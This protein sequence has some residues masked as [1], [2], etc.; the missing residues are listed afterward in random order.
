MRSVPVSPWRRLRKLT[1]IDPGSWCRSKRLSRRAKSFRRRL[2]REKLDDAHAAWPQAQGLCRPRLAQ[3]AQ[4]Q[5]QPKCV[6]AARALKLHP[7]YKRVDTCAAEFATNTA[8]MYSTYEEE[9]EANPPT[10]KRSWCWVAAPTVSARASS[11]TT[12]ACT[13]PWR[14]AKTAT[15][16][17]WSTATPKPCPPI[18]TPPI[19]STFEPLDAGRRAWKSCASKSPLGRDRAV[20]RPDAAEA[21]P[22]RW[23]AEGVPHHRH[24]PRHAST[25]PKTVSAS[26]KCSTIWASSSR[27]MPPSPRRSR[28][29]CWPPRNRLPAGG[30]P[31]L[32]AGWPRHG[33][34]A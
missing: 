26:K 22:T 20:R 19:V 33:N 17:S 9:C 23:K 1:K 28:S 31:L 29:A 12:A 27:P 8:Y 4:Y 32:C 13:P 14:C 15:R 16:P 7:V 10:T 2:L 34:R 18:T 21:W 11:L 6:S 3:V 24:Q 5:R 25:L 30:A